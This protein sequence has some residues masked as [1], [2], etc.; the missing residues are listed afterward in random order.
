M[1]IRPRDFCLKQVL[2]MCF[3]L[4]KIHNQEI[5]SMKCDFY[6]DSNNK[7]WLFY[8]QDI[9]SRNRIRSDAEKLEEEA[10][11]KEKQERLV[12]LKEQ[13]RAR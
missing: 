11:E 3:Y 10:R 2:K 5:L 13:M 12:Q 7:I 4:Q 8:A 6:R 9:L 1:E